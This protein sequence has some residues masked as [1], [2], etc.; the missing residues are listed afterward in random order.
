MKKKNLLKIEK[1][2]D[3]LME[4]YK[5][6]TERVESFIQINNT[7]YWQGLAI[8]FGLLGFFKENR[9]V[10]LALP[11]LIIIYVGIVL[12]NLQRTLYNQEY[13]IYLEKKINKICGEKLLI[14][15][16]LGYNK[17]EISNKF[18]HFNYL[19]YAMLILASIC[20]YIGYLFDKKN[21]F[22]LYFKFSITFLL[23]LLIIFFLIAIMDIPRKI[24]KIKTQYIPELQNKKGRN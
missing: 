20:I 4:E 23:I 14:Y 3:V 15:T 17:V 10:L 6:T 9:E 11:F 12:Y 16:Q 2:I 24:S 19:S 21:D 18:V 5:I 7:F 1:R 8:V 22:N 13:K